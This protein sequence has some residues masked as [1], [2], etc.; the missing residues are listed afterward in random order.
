MVWKFITIP[1]NAL[2][3]ALP[4]TVDKIQGLGAKEYVA[5]VPGDF[6]QD[7]VAA[8]DLPDY[9]Y[10]EN[11]L[12]ARKIENLH[13]F[14]YTEVE[15]SADEY[16]HFE[17]IDT[18]AD[19]YVNGN[20]E[21]SSS[22]SFLSLDVMPTWKAGRNSVVVHI[23]PVCLEARKLKTPT[24]SV[25]AFY[26]QQGLYVRKPI[27][28]FG[29]DILPRMVSA[30]IH[31]PV[32][33]LKKKTDAI[34][35]V[36]VITGSIDKEKKT[37]RLR[38]YFQLTLSGDFN[39]DYTIKIVGKC[40]DAT[41]EK[42]SV[43]WHSSHSFCVDV[44]DARLW[45]PHNYGKPNLYDV[46]VQLFY[47]G[48]LVDTYAFAYGIRTAR[49]ESNEKQF[50]FYVNDTPIFAMG[51]NWVP[52]SIF[53]GDTSRL[54][55]S[56]SLLLE[57]GA[58]M[59]RVW[60]GGYYEDD[61]FYEF[62]DR[63]GILVWQDFMM[64]C[65]IYPQ[66]ERFCEILAE[67]AEYQ[68]KRLRNH[69]SL[70]LWCGDNECDLCMESWSDF[71]RAPDSNI[72][73]REVLPKVLAVHDHTRSYIPSSP[74]IY[75]KYTESGL[76]DW[77][78]WTRTEHYASPYFLETAA[79]FVSEVGYTAFPNLD[80]LQKFIKN[81]ENVLLDDGTATDEYILHGTAPDVL[82]NT[83]YDHKVPCTCY[84]AEMTFGKRADSFEDF[85]A[86]SQ[87]TQAEAYKTWVETARVKGWS[88]IL[89][90]NLV[91]GWP[92]ISEAMVD[93][94]FEKKPSFSFVKNA[95]RLQSVILAEK[96]ANLLNVYAVN[97]GN[98]EAEIAYEVRLGEK[99]LLTGRATVAAHGRVVVGEIPTDGKSN[100]YAVSFETNGE[101]CHT[102]YQEKPR[103]LDIH[104]YLNNL[105]A[106]YAE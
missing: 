94:Y 15:A 105:Q 47:R 61:R 84:Y 23:K 83:W 3:T 7:M 63:H 18:F 30:G 85:I 64:A 65:G 92:G 5:S 2:P 87:Y 31:K 58:N 11:I 37:A 9:F 99:S 38:C 86:Q 34:D 89:L 88:G 40:G 16:L 79:R 100:F 72:L 102:H 10:S 69:A 6:I 70:V 57:S 14:Y 41:F 98:E 71:A 95:Q 77:H 56:L 20:K 45:Y 19:V 104:T 49:L 55:K 96:T 1:N 35:D 24:S 26:F 68:V 8:G 54:D 42:E 81:P 46:E 60:G 28:S 59:V 50:Q 52:T 78:L 12:L 90:W 76:I 62:C 74:Y 17:G 106:A 22:N 25:S 67:E 82:K 4:D 97:D 53:T 27:S 103:A 21:A 29:W 93:Y 36:F 43:V 51:S 80:S 91:E 39:S 66:D 101:K 13:V 48:T 32:R 75:G 73:T 33:L 44:Q